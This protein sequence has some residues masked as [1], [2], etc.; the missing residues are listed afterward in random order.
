MSARLVLVF[1]LLMQHLLV[2]TVAASV[3]MA[4]ESHSSRETPHVHSLSTLLDMLQPS[5]DQHHSGE[6]A[7]DHRQHAGSDHDCHDSLDEVHVH[8]ICPLAHSPEVP[9]QPL[10]N[11]PA[12]T[13][14]QS[15]Q[16]LTYKPLLPPPNA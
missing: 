12:I 15:Y 13:I 5:A 6:S 3:H 4:A 7:A 8:V 14:Y 10:L 1:I 2:N 16:G 9:Q 11:Q